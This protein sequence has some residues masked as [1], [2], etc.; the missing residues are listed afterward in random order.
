MKN[1]LTPFTAKNWIF[2]ANGGG[3]GRSDVSPQLWHG[4]RTD[5]ERASDSTYADETL[6]AELNV[7]HVFAVCPMP[8]RAETRRETESFLGVK[9]MCGEKDGEVPTSPVQLGGAGTRNPI[10]APSSGGGL[11]VKD[12][13]IRKNS[14]QIERFPSW[15]AG[16]SRRK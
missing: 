12:T 15:L 13:E 2:L 8:D 14:N 10:G 4:S 1:D 16:S 11:G 7:R 5:A 6:R 9:G 3:I